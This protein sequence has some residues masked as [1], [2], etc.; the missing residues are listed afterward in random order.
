MH[1]DHC[2]RKV[3]VR[4]T[5]GITGLREMPLAQIP[6]GVPVLD[7]IDKKIKTKKSIPRRRMFKCTICGRGLML[8]ENA[9]PV[10]E[11][12]KENIDEEK[13]N[14]FGCEGRPFGSSIS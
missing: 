13:D 4:D 1:C 2:G 11:H 10:S 6:G 3:V 12:L 14:S 9:V 8:R 5:V 7:P